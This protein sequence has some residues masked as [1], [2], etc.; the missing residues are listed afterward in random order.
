MTSDLPPSCLINSN[1]T[2]IF[3]FFVNYAE[4]SFLHSPFYFPFPCHYL[5]QCQLGNVFD[6]PVD[7]GTTC[8]H[9]CFHVAKPLN[10]S[11]IQL[12]TGFHLSVSLRLNY[13]RSTHLFSPKCSLCNLDR[14]T[15]LDCGVIPP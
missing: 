7:L 1:E 4:F 6:I 8:Q 5:Q 11:N 13:W 9:R 3:R 2:P 14:G 10:V 12:S 15:L